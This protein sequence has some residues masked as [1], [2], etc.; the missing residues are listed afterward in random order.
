MELNYY[1]YTDAN[2]H[3]WPKIEYL[4]NWL[5]LI[6]VLDKDY[7]VRGL[8][9]T[10]KNGYDIQPIHQKDAEPGPVCSEPEA[11]QLE[12]FTTTTYPEGTTFNY[13]NG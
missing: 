9:N 5:K 1:H 4:L 7:L 13:T 11:I 12:L 8:E 10:L 2:S 3:Y 6:A